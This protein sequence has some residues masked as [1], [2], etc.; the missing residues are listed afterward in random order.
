MSPGMVMVPGAV[1]VALALAVRSKVGRVLL[2]VAALASVVVPSVPL[3][4]AGGAESPLAS[5]GL[6][7]GDRGRRPARGG[8]PRV[9]ASPGARH[10][11][12]PCVGP[13]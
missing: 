4:D 1:L 13:I 3:D 2:I 12:Y 7:L 8:V 9:V 5:L 10:T 6:A 11:A